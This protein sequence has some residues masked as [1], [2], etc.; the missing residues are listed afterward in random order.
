MEEFRILAPCGM[1]GY[2]FPRASFERGLAKNPHAIVVDSGSTDGGPHKLGAG[3]AIVSR[4]A[5]KNDLTILVKAGREKNIPLIIGSAG[6]S[7]AQKHIE[8]TLSILDEILAE[9]D[10]APLKLAV[11]WA[12]IAR[13]DVEQ[14]IKDRKLRPMSSGVPELT[15]RRLQ[16]T[17]SIVAQMGHEPVSEA[18]REGAD[19]IICGRAYDPAPFAAPCINAGFPAAYAY[20]AGKILECAA[21]CLD[22][23]TTKDCV[24]GY[25]RQDAFVIESLNPE[26]HATPLSVAAHTFYEKSHPYL[27]PGPGYTLDLSESHFESLSDYAVKVTGSKIHKDTPYT[28]KLEGARLEAYRTLCIAGIQDALLIE[29]IEAV[30]AEVERLVRAYYRQLGQLD[31]T[32]NFRNY[33]LDAVNPNY[34]P[35][36]FVPRE[37]GVVFEVLS[38]SQ[39]VSD[40]VLSTLRS[41][42]LHYGYPGRKSTAGNLA[43]PYAPSD[44][45]YG[46]V[47]EF[48]VYHLL[49][50]EDPLRHFPIEYRVCGKE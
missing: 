11:I 7:G 16:E 41:T 14:A 47:Y 30:E 44:I 23:G 35:G 15:E 12:D 3:V 21:L 5:F 29:N 43:F 19:I 32:I 2:G 39:Q 10:F 20:H 26:R 1:L 49:E 33:G 34:D 27:L 50:V 8:W 18:L 42:F 48:S 4:N 40:D 13:E 22:P 36:D 46:P 28:L 31:F 38:S 9:N 25:I 37:I 45:S 17:H 24:M 6:G